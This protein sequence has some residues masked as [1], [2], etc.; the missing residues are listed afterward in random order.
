MYRPPCRFQSIS[1]FVRRAW[2]A[3]YNCCVALT[4]RSKSQKICAPQQ[5]N[6]GAGYLAYLSSLRTTPDALKPWPFPTAKE[7]TSLGVNSAP[8]LIPIWARC[9]QMCGSDVSVSK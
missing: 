4:K 5:W 7:P 6:R 8:S 1:S 2:I 9:H 3:K